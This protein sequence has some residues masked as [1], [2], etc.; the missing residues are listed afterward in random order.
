MSM[1]FAFRPAR[2]PLAVL[3][4]ALASGT[5]FATL[6]SPVPDSAWTPQAPAPRAVLG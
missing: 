2:S 6:A 3:R 1:P 5:V 4:R